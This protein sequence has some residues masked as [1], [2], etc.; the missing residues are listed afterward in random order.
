MFP[1][2]S[3]CDVFISHST[4]DGGAA[5]AIKQHLQ[6]AGLTCWKAPDD[7]D[8]G[9][10]WPTA[11][12]RAL[13]VCRVMVLVWSRNSL[14]SREVAKELTLAMRNGLTVVPFRIE[15]VQPSGEWDYHL[16]NTHCMDAFPGEL[17]NYVEELANRV[18][19]HLHGVGQA[20]SLPATYPNHASTHML[21]TDA[22]ALNRRSAA[23]FIAS[24]LLLVAGASVWLFSLKPSSTFQAAVSDSN[25]PSK[26]AEEGAAFEHIAYQEELEKTK[27]LREAA[28]R[29][30]DALRDAAQRAEVDKLL[31][32]KQ[33]ALEKA[34]RAEELARQA[35]ES[36]SGSTFA[37]APQDASV[38]MS[39]PISTP[40][41]INSS[42]WLF[43][44]S[45]VRV[46][47]LSE[48]QKLNPAQLWR[49]RNEI[50]A[51]RGYIFE[52][53][54]GKEFTRSL[55]ASYAPLTS[56]QNSVTAAMNAAER[57]N[58]ANIERLERAS[59]LE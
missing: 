43:A 57:A 18:R 23:L 24:G 3:S 37:S 28:E 25:V 54:R 20:A 55:G 11:I 14:A 12:T 9:E 34:S 50:F 8:P 10:S 17:Q 40:V 22:A 32:E 42:P 52:T 15:D 49:A 48:L 33:L 5:S 4:Q 41:Y 30:A 56:N 19:G 38:N 53:K 35:K 46:I 36:R 1:N 26:A 58:I 39:E 44:D 13:S 2:G 59:Q 27:A 45:S 21:R 29:E 6:A 31:A 51:R 7:I 47:A 16:A